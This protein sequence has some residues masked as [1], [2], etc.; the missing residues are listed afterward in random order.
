MGKMKGK[1]KGKLNK[2]V[3]VIKKLLDHILLI[4]NHYKWKI[5]NGWP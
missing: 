2:I 5:K 4:S 3:K 1:F